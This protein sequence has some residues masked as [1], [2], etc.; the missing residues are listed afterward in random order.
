MRHIA[1]E[2]SG[3][4]VVQSYQTVRLN[5][6]SLKKWT[7]V[8]FLHDHDLKPV[9]RRPGRNITTTSVKKIRYMHEKKLFSPIFGTAPIVCEA[10]SM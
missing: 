7:A 9:C 1:K 2:K 3:N 5:L 10:E 6:L 8:D 4:L